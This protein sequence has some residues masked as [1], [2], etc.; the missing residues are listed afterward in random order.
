VQRFDARVARS[1]IFDALVK[2]YDVL[3]GFASFDCEIAD[4]TTC[5]KK[6]SYLT[7]F[8]AA[9]EKD[10]FAASLPETQDV[11]TIEVGRGS[12]LPT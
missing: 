6:F 3:A 1:S 5:L 9:N 2:K 11:A 7:I 4:W 8:N 10:A 12:N